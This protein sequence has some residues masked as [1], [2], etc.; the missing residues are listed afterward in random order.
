MADTTPVKTTLITPLVRLSYVN[1]FQARIQTQKGKAAKPSDRPRYGCTALILP[2]DKMNAADKERLTAM[3]AAAL[4]AGREAKNGVGAEKFNLLVK[5]GKVKLMRDDIESSG[6]PIEFKYFIRPWTYGVGA[7]EAGPNGNPP[8]K[9]GA[10]PGIVS[11]FKD[12][13]TG[14]PMAITDANKVYSGCWARLSLSPY[15]TNFDNMNPSISWQLYNVQICRPPEGFSAER[16]D[17]K[18]DAADEFD[19]TREMEAADMAE[20]AAAD[21]SSGNSDADELAKLLG[22]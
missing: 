18:S 6:H 10:P 22:G 12:P 8:V 11:E 17:G 20:M 1:L 2:P 3:L 4:R 13:T 7:A 19:A 9:V 5:E 16:L 21:S 14:K 15:F